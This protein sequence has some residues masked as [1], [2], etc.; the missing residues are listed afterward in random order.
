MDPVHEQKFI[1]Y[2]N[3]PLILVACRFAVHHSLYPSG[4][5]KAGEVETAYSTWCQVLCFISS[6]TFIPI[7]ILFPVLKWS[8]II[9]ITLSWTLE[10][11]IF[12][13][14]AKQNA[15]KTAANCRYLVIRISFRTEHIFLEECFLHLWFLIGDCIIYLD[16]IIIKSR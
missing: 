11:R 14:H 4:A 3:P 7:W 13:D 1:D 12:F 9:A 16:F 2:A 5:L 10:H 8:I 6:I 15:W